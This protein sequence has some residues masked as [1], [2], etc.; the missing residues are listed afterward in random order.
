VTEGYQ[1]GEMQDVFRSIDP[2]I[3]SLIQ[4]HRK[5]SVRWMPHE[6]LPWGR[7]E[8]F[9]EKPWRP[10]QCQLRP[11]IV[12]AFETNLLTE[13]N[14]PY[15]HAIIERM[16]APDSALAEWNRLWTSEEATHSQSM[17]DYVHLMRLIDPSVLERNR[18]AFMQQGFER[19]FK[20]PFEVFAYTSAQE[21]A[22][23]ISHL[24]V[25]Q[26]AKEPVLS[27][28]LNLISRDENF[29]YIFY[30]SVVK[31]VLEIAPHLMLP[32]IMSQLFGFGMPG[33]TMEGFA[34]RSAI[35]ATER[36]FGAREFRDHVVKPILVYW[37]ID[38][39][40]NLSPEVEK[41]QERILKLERVLDRVVEREPKEGTWA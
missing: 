20:N 13:D 6:V 14:L 26:K 12:V 24:A 15:Y 4:N 28:L 27:N 8:D 1:L 19:N 22:T 33:K 32:A 41:I 34:E 38:K 17:R 18:L 11:E 40:R 2:L 5:N 9:V 30:R 7:G 36:I 16:V 31:G 37:Q 3:K 23:R 35:F 10:D 39:L 25:G 29:H 21:V